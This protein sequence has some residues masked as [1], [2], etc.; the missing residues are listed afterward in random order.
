MTDYFDDE[1]DVDVTD[2]RFARIT[3]TS[4]SPPTVY[5]EYLDGTPGHATSDDP[6]PFEK[7]TVVFISGSSMR[8]APHEMWNP[9]PRARGDEQVVRAE[10]GATPHDLR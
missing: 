4:D 8:P 3:H 10:R 1:V 2:G 5:F 7:G 9:N 6:I